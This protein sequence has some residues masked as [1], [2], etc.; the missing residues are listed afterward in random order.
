MD[1][2]MLFPDGVFASFS[3]AKLEWIV[4]NNKGM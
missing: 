3:Q 4:T 2:E 1:V